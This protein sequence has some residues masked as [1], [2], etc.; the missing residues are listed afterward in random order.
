MNRIELEEKII[1]L[2]ASQVSLEEIEVSVDSRFDADLNFDS[3]DAVELTMCIEDEFGIN[4]PDEDAER[5]FT[6]RA[7]ADYVEKNVTSE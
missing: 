1:K 2:V 4:I 3:L 7:I 5:L 6:V